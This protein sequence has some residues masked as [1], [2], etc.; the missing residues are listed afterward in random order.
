MKILFVVSAYGKPSGAEHVL[1]DFLKTTSE[2]D[3]VLLFIGPEKSFVDE[4][5]M[6]AK[7]CV[8][9]DCQEKL[10]DIV[11]R[12]VAMG[13]R[14]KH[15]CS[16][17]S[18]NKEIIALKND[19]SIEAV[20]FNN[21]FESAVFYPLFSEKKT[22]VH[23]HDM[24]NMFRPA[25]KSCV[26]KACKEACKVITASKACKRQ[27]VE[28]G[29]DQGKITVAYNGMLY[30]RKKYTGERKQLCFGFVG[31]IIKRKGFDV[32]VD[33]VNSIQAKLA[34]RI[35]VVIITNSDVGDRYF[36]ECLNKIHND[37]DKEVFVRIPREKVQSAYREMTALIVPSRFDPLPTVVLEATMAACPVFGTDKDGIPEM[38]QNKERLFRVDDSNEAVDKILRWL[39]K[40]FT[41]KARE[42]EV[43]QDYISD[44]FTVEKK[45][46]IILDLLRSLT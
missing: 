11:I 18:K 31:S 1:I 19:T 29:I 37:I 46:R 42:I 5:K 32:F 2:I 28:N 12:F 6:F 17:L 10:D 39:E 30:E 3:P 34:R 13:Q 8:Y 14:R 21:S 44:T 24:I 20:Y 25:H 26:V 45:R 27:L 35:K 22:I 40:P 16:W 41:D 33:I 15:V 7:R 43:E 23:I 4:F 9:V 36:S 38:I